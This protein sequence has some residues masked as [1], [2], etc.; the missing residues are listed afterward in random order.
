VDEAGGL[1]CALYKPDV[2]RFGEGPYPCIVSVYGG[3]GPQRVNNAW[4]MRV[5]LRSQRLA[6]E[7]FLV[8]RCDNRC[9]G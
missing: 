3:P 2:T 5:D 1:Y 6:Q 8:I 9:V 4:I 7:G